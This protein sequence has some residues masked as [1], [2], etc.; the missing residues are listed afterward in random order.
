MKTIHK[1]FASNAAKLLK[2]DSKTVHLTVTSPPYP[3]IEMWDDIFTKQNK[4]IGAALAQNNGAL[5][6]ELMHREMDKVWTELERVTVSGGF[7]CINIGDATRTI[8]QN[9]QLFSNHTRIIQKFLSLGFQNLPNII[10]RKAT[11]APN[12][13]MGSGMMPPGAYVTLEH[14]HI[15]IFRKGRKREFKTVAEKN[16]RRSSSYFWEERNI[17]FSDLWDLKGVKQS[18]KNSKTRE[19][20]AAYPF[21]LSYRL[22]NMFSVKGDNVLDPYLGTGTTVL[23]AMAAGRNSFGYDIDRVLIKD[24]PKQDF[25]SIKDSLNRMIYN[26]LK[27]H[28]AFI[29]ERKK[30]KGEHSNK[31]LSKHYDFGVMT[32]VERHLVLNYLEGIEMVAPNKLECTYFEEARWIHPPIQDSLVE[33]K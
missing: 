23:G 7:V 21:E 31:H 10:W 3:M 26:R 4:K 14:E 8:D 2:I 30:S 5:A 12:K 1:L 18:I 15:L 19:R 9:F 6:F 17:W 33:K 27:R 11:N 22:I 28:K 16:V 25:V 13:F 24:F 29:K 32:A 20:S